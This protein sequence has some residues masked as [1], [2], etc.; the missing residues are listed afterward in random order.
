MLLAPIA[1]SVC[2]SFLAVGGPCDCCVTVCHVYQKSVTYECCPRVEWADH[3]SLIV[4]GISDGHGD[5]H[6]RGASW[7]VLVLSSCRL[8]LSMSKSQCV[9][10]GV[11]VQ[12]FF[13]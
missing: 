3:G 9:V 10:S 12:F 2:G 7:S 13:F 11:T 5:R 1:T 8:R 4:L 6:D